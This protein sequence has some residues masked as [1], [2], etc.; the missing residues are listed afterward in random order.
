M[1]TTCPKDKY[2]KHRRKHVPVGPW[3]RDGDDM[4]RP[5]KLVCVKCGHVREHDPDD[6]C[7]WLWSLA[8]IN[9]MLSI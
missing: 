2:G 5:V 4:R 8:S 6:Q 9:A 7:T 3:E 1:A